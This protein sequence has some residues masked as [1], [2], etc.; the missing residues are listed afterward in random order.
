MRNDPTN[1][2]WFLAGLGLGAA[3]GVLLAPKAGSET[4][5]LIGTRA[6]EAR[7]YLSTH[8]QDY[9]DRGRELYERGRQLADE[10]ADMFDEGRRMVEQA[11]S[12]LGKV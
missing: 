3:A 2:V 7:Q 12:E 6:G 4:R 5:R 9:Y 1:L 10:A 11:Q 8:G